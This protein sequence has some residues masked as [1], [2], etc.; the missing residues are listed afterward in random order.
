MFSGFNTDPPVGKC[1][2]YTYKHVKTLLNTPETFKLFYKNNAVKT[3]ILERYV[4][5]SIKISA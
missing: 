4:Q 1:Y 3:A 2:M 5:F